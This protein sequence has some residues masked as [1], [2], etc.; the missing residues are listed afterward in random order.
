MKAILI[1][2]DTDLSTLPSGKY[3]YRREN[4]SI[5]V[6]SVNNDPSKTDQSFAEQCD[7][8]NIIKRYQQTGQVTHLAKNQGI[9]SDVSEIPDLQGAFQAVQ[10]A[11]FAFS[12]LPASIRDRFKNNP[13]EFV[14]FL[15]NPENDAEAISLGL[16]TSTQTGT[17]PKEESGN[18]RKRVSKTTTVNVPEHTDTQNDDNSNDD[19]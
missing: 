15:Q 17:L 9:Y 13:I 8:N 19:E 2:S 7:I 6:F 3:K 10:D 1:D 4:G 12:T 14:E 5:R 16:K 18:K 11:S